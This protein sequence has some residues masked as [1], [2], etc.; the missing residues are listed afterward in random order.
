MTRTSEQT[1]AHAAAVRDHWWWRPGWRAGREFY[2]WHLTFPTAHNLHAL[3]DA[4][5]DQLR[6]LPGLDMVPRQWLHLTMQGIGFTD[7]ITEADAGQITAAARR[8]LHAIAAPRVTFHRA[9][10]RPEAVVLPATPATAVAQIRNA[11]RDAITDV[12]GTAPDEPAA[13]NGYVPHVTV[14]YANHDSPATPILAATEAVHAQPATV[15]IDTASLI[16]LN[17]DHRFY[18][19]R[20]HA[21]AQLGR[22]LAPS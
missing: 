20:D 12:T 21:R 6:A 7:E 8:R 16:I 19:W 9:L 11:I 4:H 5:Q 1:P 22:S 13:S 17:R 2:T 3:V 14:A 15:T 18:Q 10:L